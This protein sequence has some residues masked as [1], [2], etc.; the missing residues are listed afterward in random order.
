VTA[1][2]LAE[3]ERDL[4]E[5]Q[6]RHAQK[7]ESLGTMAGGIAHDFNNLLM[8]VL[9]HADLAR[10]EIEDGVDPLRSLD[11][12][13]AAAE[14]AASL[15]KQL[16]AF[17]GRG[18]LETRPVDPSRLIH[19]IAGLLKL[20]SRQARLKLDLAP[21]LP[22]VAGDPQQLRQVVVDLVRNAAEAIGDGPGS[23]T[24]RA[25]VVD[26]TRADLKGLHVRDELEPG[27]HISIRVEDTGCGLAPEEISRIFDP[28]YT[29]KFTGRGLGLAAVLGIV[30]G[31][32]GAIRVDSDPGA[33]TTIE[34]LLPCG[35]RE[36]EGEAA[37]PESA[38]ALAGGAGTIL[39]VDDDPAVLDIAGHLLRKLGFTALLAADGAEACALYREEGER[40]ALVILDM[41]M[42]GL[43]GAA[44]SE[45]L[46]RIDPGVRILL[47]SGFSE[48]TA[49]ARIPA[50]GVAGFLQKPYTLTGLQ[51]VLDRILDG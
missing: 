46:R 45:E 30:R 31:H 18:R 37:A 47:S 27:R 4:L 11:Q 50:D 7:L 40:I 3:R 13:R 28:F 8:S 33:G 44:T 20:S 12:I 36:E 48:E 16:L 25:G 15:C 32:R 17:A 42:P 29:T 51:A 19:D 5:R 1:A 2:R 26:C 9:G 35:G 10:T 38:R 14:R 21:G 23:I 49:T 39:V 6:L 43:D 22:A 41:T 24:V 34:V